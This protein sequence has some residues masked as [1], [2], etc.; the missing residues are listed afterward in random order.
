M[1]AVIL[2][3]GYGKRL[4]PYTDHTPKPALLI[5]GKPLIERTFLA[6]PDTVEQVTIVFG[7]LGSQIHDMVGGS[8]HGRT[9]SYVE[10]PPDVGTAA[11]LA[12]A[13]VSLPG[14]FL[15][16]N[17]DDLYVKKD[18]EQL[19][20]YERSLLVHDEPRDTG[21][22]MTSAIVS[23]DGR[24]QGLAGVPS[25]TGLRIAGAYVLTQSFFKIPM[26]GIRVHDRTEY[27]IPHTLASVAQNFAYQVV[28]A[29]WWH[30]IGTPEQYDAS[31]H[32]R[33][34]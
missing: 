1:H 10:S 19:V 25:M 14:R 13:K 5:A 20:E 3:A 21:E 32:L 11:S 8:F 26:V 9:V 22:P 12:L 27:S 23:S 6:L 29:S 18:L 16:L 31:Q 2:A 15:V 24:F 34:T 33:F 4:R 28:R 30:Q 17:G 7:Y